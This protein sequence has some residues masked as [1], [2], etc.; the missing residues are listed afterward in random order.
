MRLAGRV[1]L[2]ART[3]VICLA[4]LG[5]PAGVARL[6][7]YFRALGAE[8]FVH[9]DAKAGLEPYEALEDPPA[10]RLLRTRQ[11]IFWGGFNTVRAIIAAVEAAQSIAPY[12]RFVLLTEDSVPLLTPRA[13]AECL[14]TET[15]WIDTHQT[16]LAWVWQR[17]NEFFC[18]DSGATSPRPIAAGERAFTADTLS[19]IERMRRLAEH[20]KTPLAVL[21]HGSGWWALSADALN[22][23]LER[24]RRDRRLRESFE[25]SAIPEE[26]YFHTI[27]AL[28]GRPML[29]AGCMYADFSR[30]PKPYVFHDPGEINTL[31]DSVPHLF[32]RKVPLRSEA[33]DQFVRDLTAAG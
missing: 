11:D 5:D 26:Q 22:V 21:H 2:S 14:A 20:G 17:Y 30:D 12:R 28:S 3:A 29:A 32:L 7:G 19:R 27:L 15:E 16:T 18:F 33:I 24:H 23:I 6:S 31:R 13:L 10:V 25:F 8:M 9:V 1:T 4:Y